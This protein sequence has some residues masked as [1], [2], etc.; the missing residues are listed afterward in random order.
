MK[1]TKIKGGSVFRKIAMGSWWTAG[2]PSVYGILEIDATQAL[3]YMA[4]IHQK[5]KER[6][7]ISH[8]VGRAVAVAM[9]ERPEING[10]IKWSRIYQRDSV[11]LFYQVN[12]PGKEGDPVGKATLSG[13]TV[14]GAENLDVLGIA[15]VLNDKSKS[16]KETGEGEL[17]SAAKGMALV[18][19]S[20][21]R[22][23][24]TAVGFLNYNLGLPVHW[25]GLPKDPFGSVM[26][27]NIGA[28][29]GDLALAPLVPYSRVPLLLAIGI[30]KER[31]WVVNGQV[32]VR[33][34]FRVGVTF[35]HRFM[36]GSHAARMSEIFERCFQDPWKHL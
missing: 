36:D 30:I 8:L 21:V 10:M 24:L 3:E 19:W 33:P 31:P 25:F 2:D 18:P 35:D 32:V 23:A 11:D 14:R 27:T 16:L 20:L 4:E 1:L 29:G 9:K 15:R 34:V 5:T 13:V 6:I 28:L 12:V 26:I 17:T 22:Y 7:S